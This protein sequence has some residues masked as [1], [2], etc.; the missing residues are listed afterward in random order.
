MNKILFGLLAIS[1]LVISGCA[2]SIK[3]G[4]VQTLKQYYTHEPLKEGQN[5][6]PLDLAARAKIADKYKCS[7]VQL[8]EGVSNDCYIFGGDTITLVDEDGYSREYSTSFG[9]IPDYL[10]DVLQEGDTCN[11][12]F[13]RYIKGDIIDVNECDEISM[14][15]LEENK[16][17]YNY[18][19]EHTFSIK[20]LLLDENNNKEN[21]FG[22][23][24]TLKEINPDKSFTL[25]YKGGEV[26]LG[27]G[28]EKIV[29]C[30]VIAYDTA[31]L[32]EGSVFIKVKKSDLCEDI[33]Y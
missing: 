29:D 11:F 3:I 25:S 22:K 19:S 14:E 5:Y 9:Q 27:P 31:Y 26:L 12:I 17:K 7:D 24:F 15:E 20:K 21:I 8:P 6:M 2:S 16:Q 23:E 1:L 10:F 18:E 28:D 4:G 32:D 30:I 33:Q 13:D